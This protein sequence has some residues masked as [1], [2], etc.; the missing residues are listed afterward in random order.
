MKYIYDEADEEEKQTIGRRKMARNADSPE[1]EITLGTRSILG[2]FFGLILICGVF[3]GLGYSVGRGST[4]RM[5]AAA[6]PTDTGAIEQSRLAKPSA[7]ET[8]SAVEPASPQTTALA[9][10]TTPAEAAATDGSAPSSL[11]AAAPGPVSKPAAAVAELGADASAAA[12]APRPAMQTAT[13]APP[14]VTRAVMQSATPAPTLQRA[15]MVQ[16]A[17][18]NSYMVQ[19]AAVRAP[20]AASILVTALQKHGFSAAVH[21]DPQDQLLHV[22][23]GPFTTRAEANAMRARLMADGYNAVLK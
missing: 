7:D 5:I 15:A 4:A 13:P 6:P 16:P 20:Q 3:F 11:P 17:P 12:P 10:S 23:I 18:A 14:P 9:G 2:I 19:V 21:S 1:T 8:L 22:Q